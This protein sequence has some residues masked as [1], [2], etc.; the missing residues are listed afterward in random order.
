M[1]VGLAPAR[2]GDAPAEADD[3]PVVGRPAR[4]PFS[5][6]SGSFEIQARAEPLTVRADDPI[7]FTLTVRATAPVRHPPRRPD[8]RL[9]KEFAERF[10]IE[11]GEPGERQPDKDTREFV[12]LLKPR[13]IDVSEIPGLPF[14]YFNP[15][16]PP[17]GTGFQTSYTDEIPVKIL[18]ADEYS[19]LPALG[20]EVYHLETG[21]GV[22][23]RHR[24]AA[25]PTAM[26]M[27][28]LIAG[29]PL[30][31]GAWYVIWRRRHPDLAR[32]VR[33]RHSQAARRSLRLLRQAS[34]LPAPER[35]NR[36]VDAVTAYLHDRF[37]LASAQPTPA[38]AAESLRRAGCAAPVAIAAEKF[39]RACDA[40]RYGPIA[41]GERLA[42][43]AARFILDVEAETWAFQRS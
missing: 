37:E 11:D 16:I 29:P 3:I 33:R 24:A 19:P 31:C 7:T 1:L 9:L 35:A 13:R 32:Q 4:Y 25:P 20:D 36:T 42:G 12:Y 23:A 14:V 43:D 10:Y 6:G 21:P 8:L 5:G 26:A 15:A 17:A 22:L 30:V 2:A 18:S 27:A 39:M 38:E 40:A 34:R 28:L 41:D